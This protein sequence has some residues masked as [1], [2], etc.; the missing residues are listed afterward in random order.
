MK[1]ISERQQ[2]ILAFFESYS[3]EH[4]HAPT[5]R[6][7]GAATDIAS[8]SLVRYYLRRLERAGHL[9]TLFIVT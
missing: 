6:E 8:T 4:G 9:R 1:Q 5:L 2:R 7:I 3:A